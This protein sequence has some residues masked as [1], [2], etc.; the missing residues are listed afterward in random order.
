VGGNV[1]IDS[2]TLLVTD[3][4]NL[5][6]KPAQSFRCAHTD[7]VCVCIFIGVSALTCMSICV[8]TVFLKNILSNYTEETH[9]KLNSLHMHSVHVYFNYYSS[10]ASLR[11]RL[12][13]IG[14]RRTSS[15]SRSAHPLDSWTNFKWPVGLTFPQ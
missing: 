15:T 11:F 3:F 5:K 8:Y 14:H 1:P 4:V 7:R 9:I 13:N 10:M 2:E 12:T 6:I